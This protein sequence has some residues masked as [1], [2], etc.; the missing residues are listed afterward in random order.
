MK[1]TL[2]GVK[3]I[4]MRMSGCRVCGLRKQILRKREIKYAKTV[5]FDGINVILSF[6]LYKY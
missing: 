5:S 2:K 1:K 4:I 3:E 6:V